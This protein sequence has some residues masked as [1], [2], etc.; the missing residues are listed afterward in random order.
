MATH[1][2]VYLLVVYIQIEE[3][4]GMRVCTNWFGNSGRCHF[5]HYGLKCF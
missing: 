2:S 5:V 4:W 3:E 1:G